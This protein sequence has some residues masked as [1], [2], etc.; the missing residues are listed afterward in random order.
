ME[1]KKNKVFEEIDNIKEHPIY[2]EAMRL[3]FAN[4]KSMGAKVYGIIFGMIFL[5]ILFL[6]V[7]DHIAGAKCLKECQ[8]EGKITDCND[9]CY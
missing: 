8:T 5:V 1:E 6:F 7:S 3:H 4:F 9:F 2:K